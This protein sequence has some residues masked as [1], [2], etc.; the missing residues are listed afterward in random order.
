MHL[1]A[2]LDPRTSQP[3]GVQVILLGGQI[4]YGIGITSA[5]ACQGYICGN[6][7]AVIC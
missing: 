3:I 1:V 7:D 2:A 4:K 5:E 6:P